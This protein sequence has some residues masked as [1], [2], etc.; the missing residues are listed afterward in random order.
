MSTVN[1]Q[2]GIAD[3]A[4]ALPGPAV[5]I[6]DWALEEGINDDLVRDL[7]ENGCRYFHIGTD[8][9][10]ADLIAMAIE[11]LSL[12]RP[13][14]LGEVRYLIHAHTEAFSIPPPPVS[15][16]GEIT[17]RFGLELTMSFSVGHV[18]CASVINAIDWCARLL[19]SDPEAE[20]GLVVTSDRVFG[21]AKHRLRQDAGIQSD[22]GSAILISK[23]ELRCRIGAV[24]VKN[25]ARLHEGPNNVQNA[26]AIAR[27]TWLHTK[28]LF[29]E[30]GER[31]GIPVE[32][33]GVILPI[34][35]D[36]HY[37]IQIAKAMSLPES[38]LFL[39]NIRIRGHACCADFAVNLVDHGFARID[40][41]EPVLLCG[42]SNVGAYA[43]ISLLPLRQ[44]AQSR[45]D[46]SQSLEAA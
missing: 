33:H 29:L 7:I 40:R 2:I 27:Y 5:D 22:G 23:S 11:R 13:K 4:Y 34:N 15:V 16:L 24:S 9:S 45:S 26:A 42:Q 46:L 38:S 31:S 10:D 25:F 37:W 8:M 43:A 14:L 35:A 28:Q 18:A 3:A 44:P 36:R 17:D 1:D 12:R 41:G 20:Y 32:K 21:N 6:V 19:A 30:H 39:D